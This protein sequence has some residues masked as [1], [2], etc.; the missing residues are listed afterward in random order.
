MRRR[1]HLFLVFLGLIFASCRSQ[2]AE[3]EMW[4]EYLGQNIVIGIPADN[5]TRAN[6]QLLEDIRPAGIVMYRR[7]FQ[8][9][10]QY[11]QLIDDLQQ[12][13]LRT[14][15]SLYF[16]M[17]DE[18]PGGVQRLGLFG[19]T[20]TK[21]YPD[22]ESIDEGLTV[23]K[24]LG[25]NVILGPLADFAFNRNT[26]MAQRMR[27]FGQMKNLT[28]LNGDF[29]AATRAHGMSATLKHFPGMGVFRQDPHQT[30]PRGNIPAKIFEESLS[31]FKQGIA[32]GA[33]FVMTGH[34]IYQNVDPHQSSTLSPLVVKSLLRDKLHFK[35]LILSDDISEMIYSPDPKLE[36]DEATILALKAGHN[37]VMF[38]HQLG[39]TQRT[40]HAILE[41]MKADPELRK[42]VRENYDRVKEFKRERL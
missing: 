2:P 6:R 5:L 7:S 26:F 20:S 9:I 31:V 28:A 22:K 34:G 37:L 1:H 10:E 19:G 29:I 12:I 40:L 8:S 14:T 36:K 42:V 15:S 23:L 18:E 39:Q 25:V 21:K 24:D 3:K 35:G 38:S 17:I 11:K 32:D 27:F 13:A 33:D 4:A 16:I 30:I 41:K